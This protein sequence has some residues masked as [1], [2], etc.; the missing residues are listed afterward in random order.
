MIKVGILGC[1]N[2]AKRS[3]IPAF[4]KHAA[5]EVVAIASRTPEK[6]SDLAAQYN[7]MACDYD[8]LII[9][10]DVELIYCPL[11]TGLHHEWVKKALVAG[12]HVLCEKSLACNLSEAEDLV[13][14]ARKNSRFLM[15][16]F[17]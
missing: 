15:E 2:I 16:S 1:A 17:H 5:F 6:A 9:A 13:A 14:T 12:K 11:P 3:L 10:P 4:A 7:C 8:G